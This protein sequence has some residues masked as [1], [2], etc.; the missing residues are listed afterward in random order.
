[1]EIILVKPKSKQA[2]GFLKTLL[3]KLNLVESIE[4]ID[5]K[6]HTPNKETIKAIMEARERK[7]YRAKSVK[8]LMKDLHS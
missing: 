5:F 1:M 2:I 6:G 8:E 4:V 3:S 7:G